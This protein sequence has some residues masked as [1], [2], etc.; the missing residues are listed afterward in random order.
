MASS[1][2]HPR[3]PIST[4]HHRCRESPRFRSSSSPGTRP[5]TQRTPEVTSSSTF[6]VS[7]PVAFPSRFIVHPN[8]FACAASCGRFLHSSFR[9][10]I[11]RHG[12][13]THNRPGG[14]SPL[15]SVGRI[16]L[17][18]TKHS[19]AKS[20]NDA[21]GVSCHGAASPNNADAIP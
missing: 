18:L 6:E 5:R 8:L 7:I 19:A 2:P 13:G 10:D 11:A 14:P 16:P 21:P 3:P 15:I 17:Q 20:P 9:P 12:A 1:K 4:R